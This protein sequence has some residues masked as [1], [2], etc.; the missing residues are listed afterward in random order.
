MPVYVEQHPVCD[1]HASVC[2]LLHVA[3]DRNNLNG[4]ATKA[5]SAITAICVDRKT[6]WKDLAMPSES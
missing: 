5:V 1:K 6:E 2:D 4:I 3:V